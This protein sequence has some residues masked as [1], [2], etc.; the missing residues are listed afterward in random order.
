[1][2]FSN[3]NEFTFIWSIL[4]HLKAL[5][6]ETV[7]T[8]HGVS[9]ISIG[10]CLVS[11]WKTIQDEC[12]KPFPPFSTGNSSPKSEIALIVVKRNWPLGALPAYLP[13]PLSLTPLPCSSGRVFALLITLA[14]ISLLIYPQILPLHQGPGQTSSLE[15]CLVPEAE[16]SCPR[17]CD[18]LRV[19][20]YR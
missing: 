18:I 1:M 10:K 9:I 13:A 14:C 7:T 6:V 5:R 4:P 15:P 11:E 16:I 12:N 8:L 19:L 17:T 20:L 3:I 2:N